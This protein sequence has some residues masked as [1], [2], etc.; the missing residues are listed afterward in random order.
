VLLLVTVHQ[1]LT[2]LRAVLH[3]QQSALVHNLHP[4]ADRWTLTVLAVLCSH[5]HSMGTGTALFGKLL[6]KLPVGE[7][8]QVCGFFI[9]QHFSICHL[10][11]HD[12]LRATSLRLL[13]E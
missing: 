4:G 10:T 8:G 7:T 6:A 11:P 9:T 1:S 3:T 5:K 2:L 13:L 12:S